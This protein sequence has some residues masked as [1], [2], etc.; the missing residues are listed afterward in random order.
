MLRSCI[1]S[2]FFS[3]L[4]FR[5][6]KHLDNKHTVFGKIVGGIDTLASME[7]TETDNKDKPIEDI[8]I[9]RTSV[10]VD[11]FTEVDEEVSEIVSCLTL[12]FSI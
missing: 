1:G 4:T 8:V 10:F 12:Y 3:F 5:S 7:R 2:L 9:E 6:A 11:P